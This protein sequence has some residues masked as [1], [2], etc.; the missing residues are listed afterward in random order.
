MVPLC[1]WAFRFKRL[2]LILAGSAGSLKDPPRVSHDPSADGLC[3]IPATVDWR[4]RPV[5]LVGVG[6]RA[7][8]PPRQHDRGDAPPGRNLRMD[9]RESP[10]LRG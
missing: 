10:D 2:Q 6:V 8:H 9:G 5:G 7:A 3:H 1:G 4:G